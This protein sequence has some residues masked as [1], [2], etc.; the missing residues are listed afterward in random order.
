MKECFLVASETLFDPFPN[1]DKIIAE[2]KK[3]PLSR[4]TCT[5][6]CEQLAD[7]VLQQLIFK[8]RTTLAW[9]IAVDESTDVSDT[10]Q[11]L[12]FVRY[13]DKDSKSVNEDLLGLCSLEDT[14][15][16]TDIF[17]AVVSLVE[18]YL[19][20]WETLVSVSTDGA[21]NMIGSKSGFVELLKKKLIG[22]NCFQTIALYT[23]KRFVLSSSVEMR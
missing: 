23:N 20:N 4:E 1:R 19:L 21:P 15:T 7:D 14:T 13:F 5:R 16:A 11:L 22:I 12:I 10:A 9:S 2:I 6:R 18:S 8:L 17:N 3:M